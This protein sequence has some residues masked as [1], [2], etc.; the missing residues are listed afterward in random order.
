MKRLIEVSN[1][2]DVSPPYRNTPIGKLLAYH[3]LNSPHKDYES[4]EILVGMCMDHRKKLNI[5]ER[6]AYIIRDG[7][8]TLINKDFKVSYAVGVGGIKYIALIAHTDCGMVNVADRKEK[9]VEGLVN[10]A[11]WERNK[12]IEHFEQCAPQSDIGNEV[13]F[14]LRETN[15]LRELYPKIVIVPLMYKVEDNQLYLIEE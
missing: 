3:N 4:A 8:G 9:F 5:P 13:D 14:V 2:T 10:N 12:A 7:G 11:G 6:F 15:R 1:V